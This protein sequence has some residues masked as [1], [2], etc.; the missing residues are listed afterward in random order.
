MCAFK[1]SSTA[2]HHFKLNAARTAIISHTILSD[3]V[4]YQKIQCR[5][6]VLTG[7]DGALYY[8]EGGGY[9]EYN[10]P[11]K[12]LSRTTSFTPSTV[13]V[14]PAA[15]RAGDVFTYTVRVSHVGTLSNT[16]D[17]VAALSPRTTVESLSPGMH[18][19]LG[20]VSWSRL[21]TGIQAVTGTIAVR[22][23]D[24]MTTP[25]LITV[26]IDIYAPNLPVV[27]LSATTLV[28]G[29]P[30]FLPVIRR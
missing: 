23:T 26:P 28:N 30:I 6:D 19:H 10:G 1:D 15:V 3:T 18:E 4:T 25:Y 5:T 21:L 17:L 8:S 20:E 14:N 13:S 22:V 24:S 12:R 27:N 9:A 11:I 2:I 16:F 29:I 7:P